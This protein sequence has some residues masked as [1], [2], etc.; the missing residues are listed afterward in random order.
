MD[1]LLD[2]DGIETRRTD[3]PAGLFLSRRGAWY[4]DGD[5]VKH[6]GLEGLLHRS[7]V[8]DDAGQL[9]VST[10]RD[11]L[12]FVAEDA[13]FIVRTVA[14]DDLVLSDGTREHL[15]GKR[16]YIDDD[17]RVRCVVKQ[18]RFWA[19]LSRSAT[20][21]VVH[22]RALTPLSEEGAP[23]WSL[24]PVAMPDGLEDVR[25]AEP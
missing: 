10:G 4:H 15:E 23:S 7:I 20:Q 8:R 2:D 22:T 13:P 1:A 5:R 16:L 25:K 3:A 6:A 21:G 18:G 17:G 24:P 19:V 12:P 14:G 11:T 9:L